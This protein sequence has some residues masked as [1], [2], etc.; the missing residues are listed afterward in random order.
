[1][2]LSDLDSDIGED[3]E[4]EEECVYTDDD[5]DDELRRIHAVIRKTRPPIYKDIFITTR[6]YALDASYSCNNV[7]FTKKNTDDENMVFLLTESNKFHGHLPAN[8]TVGV[9]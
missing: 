4:L 9:T 5:I 3:I 7:M 8:T 6:L 2:E 1:M